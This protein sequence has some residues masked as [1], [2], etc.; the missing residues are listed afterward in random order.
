MI[1]GASCAASAGSGVAV[2]VAVGV[3]VGVAVGVPVAVGV[4]VGV[5]EGLGVAVVDE[6]VS[7]LQPAS[8]RRATTARVATRRREGV[9]DTSVMTDEDTKPRWDRRRVVG[10]IRQSVLE[11]V[12]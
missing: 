10:F 7:P 6:P 5:G 1:P 2:G 4:V 9:A 3:D 8:T 11:T 12:W